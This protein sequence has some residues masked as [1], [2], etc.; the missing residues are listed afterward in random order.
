MSPHL[1]HVGAFGQAPPPELTATSRRAQRERGIETFA[2][3]PTLG[4]NPDFIDTLA[5]VVME[6]LPDLSR[7]SMQQINMGTPVTLNTV[8]EYT[9][10]H[11][12]FTETSDNNTHQ[13]QPTRVNHTFAHARSQRAHVP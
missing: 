13:R 8:H 1:L 6:A 11:T 9:R 5:T 10:T 2:R 3:V 12:L 4:T 7:P